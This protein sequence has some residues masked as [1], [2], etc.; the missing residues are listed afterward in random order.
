MHKLVNDQ[1]GQPLSEAQIEAAKLELEQQQAPNADMGKTTVSEENL[2]AAVASS[3][4]AAA[5]AAASG[6]PT[7][8]A[9]S[10]E[11]AATS[12]ALSSN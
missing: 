3:S 10:T 8:T 12:V 2:D 1:D 5:A 4:A 7:I 9:D 6:P 11:D